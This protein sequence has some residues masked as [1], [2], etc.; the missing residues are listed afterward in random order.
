MP[1]LAADEVLHHPRMLGRIVDNEE[2]KGFGHRCDAPPA[3]AAAEDAGDLTAKAAQKSLDRA[4]RRA[5]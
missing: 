1:S 5:A 4:A 3:L 2:A